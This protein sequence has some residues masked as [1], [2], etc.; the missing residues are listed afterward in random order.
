M[1]IKIKLLKQNHLV[2]HCMEKKCCFV[3][4]EEKKKEEKKGKKKK[5]PPILKASSLFVSFFKGLDLQ[6][7]RQIAVQS[8]SSYP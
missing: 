8:L 4:T 6:P 3:L 5:K 7:M 1:W 2:S